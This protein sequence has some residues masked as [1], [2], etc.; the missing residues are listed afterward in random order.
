MEVVGGVQTKRHYLEYQKWADG[1]VIVP[2]LN[3]NGVDIPDV[4]LT[5]MA[6]NPERVRIRASCWTAVQLLYTACLEKDTRGEGWGVDST[7]E[8]MVM[9]AFDPS[10]YHV[11]VAAP[12]QV[13]GT[14]Y[15]QT[16]LT[17]GLVNLITGEEYTSWPPEGFVSFGDSHS[18]NRMGAF[19]SGTDDRDELSKPGFHIVAGEYTKKNGEWHYALALSIVAGGKR[20]KHKLDLDTMKVSD[21]EISDFIDMTWMPEISLHPKVWEYVSTSYP[22]GW[23]DS[24]RDSFGR[25]ETPYELVPYSGGGTH[26]SWEGYGAWPDRTV[27]NGESYAEYFERMRAKEAAAELEN[28]FTGGTS[29]TRLSEDVI[30]EVLAQVDT[31]KDI[32]GQ[33][34]MFPESAPTE[35]AKK[36]AAWEKKYLMLEVEAMWDAMDRVIALCNRDPS[37]G[38]QILAK[39]LNYTGMFKTVKVRKADSRKPKGGGK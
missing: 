26:H 6:L 15:V 27:D 35:K 5:A 4:L 38:R 7:T 37:K 20:Y 13:V 28:P 2:A 8:V 11:I 18:H 1:I 24:G 31:P 33:T 34:V 39:A 36:A 17:K 3:P 32:P 14:A 21:M 23:K 9:F 12:R 10:D 22:T 19:F 29:D 25:K 30:E 16:D